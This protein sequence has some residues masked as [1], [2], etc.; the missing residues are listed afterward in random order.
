M[1][2]LT[3]AKLS[4]IKQ[5]VNFNHSDWNSPY[6]KKALD[7]LE[8]VGIPKQQV[9]NDVNVEIAS[10]LGRYVKI[11]PRLM[12]DMYN[13]AIESQIFNYFWKHTDPEQVRT[14]IGAPKFQRSTMQRLLGEMAGANQGEFFP[15]RS[16]TA[17]RALHHPTVEYAEDEDKYK[18]IETAAAT[19]SGNFIFNTKFMQGLINYAHIKGVQP[20]SSYFKNNGGTIPDEYAYAEFVLAHE[21]LHYTHSDFHR[22]HSI[23]KP[24]HKL[25]NI[26]GDLRSNYTLVKSGYTQL[27]MG[28]YSSEFNYDKFKDF[29][30]LYEAIKAEYDKL[31]SEEK[32]KASD[33]MDKQSN[34]DHTEGQEDGASSE[35]A[36]NASKVTADE[37]DKHSEKQNDAL[38][39]GKKTAESGSA[40]SSAYDKTATSD[41]TP[42]Q[43]GGKDLQQIEVTV[44]PTMNWKQVISKFVSTAKPKMESSWAAVSKRSAATALSVAQRGAGAMKPGVKPNQQELAKLAIVIDSSGSMGGVAAKALAEATKLIATVVPK[45]DFFIV[46]FSGEYHI[47]RC[48]YSKNT[49]IQVSDITQKTGKQMMLKD[50]LSSFQGGGTEF[51]NVEKVIT[52]LIADKNNILLVTDTD[53]I[54]GKNLEAFSQMIIRNK[55]FLHVVLASY[56]DYK[57]VSEKI[58]FPPATLTHF[59]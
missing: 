6:I 9:V 15:L 41:G 24:S 23:H 8:Q 55:Q 59:K 43:G 42:G 2:T 35:E 31:P 34:D 13:N 27:P 37:M 17:P 22:Q 16:V 56:N 5:N 14:L 48:N 39:K 40:A 12:Q 38:D 19:P 11:V 58:P 30:A 4:N 18:S 51:Y 7:V 54:G 53:I 21:L 10:N 28:L 44:K 46:L 50:L 33:F 26:A 29:N 57:I 49:A 3:E 52:S 36:Q 32:E 20:T 25:I 45:S 1:T 47:F